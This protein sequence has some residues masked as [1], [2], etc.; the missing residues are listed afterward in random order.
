MSLATRYFRSSS[1]MRS[2]TGPTWKTTSKENTLGRA[3]PGLAGP[4]QVKSSIFPFGPTLWS[5]SRRTATVP[6]DV[7][8]GSKAAVAGRRM[9]QPVYP[10]LRKYLERSGTYASCHQPTCS[11][12]SAATALSDAAPHVFGSRLNPMAVT[13]IGFVNEYDAHPASKS[14]TIFAY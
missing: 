10:Q 13:S 9:A 12:T 8:S 6:R 2:T 1:L 11:I 5:A 7:G 4:G 14:R 3:G